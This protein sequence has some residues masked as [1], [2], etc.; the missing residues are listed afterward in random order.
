LQRAGL[1]IIITR[2]RAPTRRRASPPAWRWGRR[3]S[4]AVGELPVTLIRRDSQLTATLLPAGL[5]GLL[6]DL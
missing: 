1:I 4:L 2:N 6:V 3:L 5:L